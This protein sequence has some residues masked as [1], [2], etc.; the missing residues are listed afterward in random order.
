M[1]QRSFRVLVLGAGLFGMCAS[2]AS[3]D[4]P[5]LAPGT[6][7]RISARGAVEIPGVVKIFRQ[8][9]ATPGAIVA[10]DARLVAVRLAGDSV[11]LALPRP[12]ARPTGR[13]VAID[14]DGV[15]VKFDGYRAPFRVPAAALASL[16]VN[17]GGR[18]NVLKSIGIGLGV[19]ALAGV[20]LGAASG[21]DEKGFMSF[22]AGEKAA[23][24]GVGLGLIGGVVGAVAGISDRPARWEPVELG[25]RHVGVFVEPRRDAGAAI[26]LRVAF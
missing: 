16:E 21:D 5:V 7:V 17:R 2:G 18:R 25:Q 12:G 10:D 8:G 19:G 11:P 3:G 23:I 15:V 14:E 9:I 1:S 22:T 4:E 6:Q 13:L 26:G 20:A 24:Y